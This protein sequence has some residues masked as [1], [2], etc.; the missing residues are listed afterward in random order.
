MFVPLLQPWSTAT[1]QT[2]NSRI[3]A[4]ASD[5]ISMQHLT[6]EMPGGFHELKHL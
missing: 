4:T 1:S 3:A 2:T 6:N 5:F